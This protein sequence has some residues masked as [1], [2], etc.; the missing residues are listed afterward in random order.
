MRLEQ[1]ILWNISDYRIALFCVPH[2]KHF[3]YHKYLS[4]LTLV[5]LGPEDWTQVEGMPWDVRG[6]CDLHIVVRFASW[7]MTILARLQRRWQ[8]QNLFPGVGYK[9]STNGHWP[10]SC[11]TDDKWLLGTGLFLFCLF[12]FTVF[13]KFYSSVCSVLA[14]VKCLLCCLKVCG[15]KFLCF[16]FLLQL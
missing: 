9:V 11:S 12:C 1:G 15:F 10:S 4:Y 3:L 14:S 5:Y 13:Q 6:T 7:S 2:S 16:I 8:N